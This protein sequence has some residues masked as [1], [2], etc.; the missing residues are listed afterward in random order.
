MKKKRP[1]S[2]VIICLL[3]LSV[4][5]VF[6]EQLLRN[7]LIGSLFTKTMVDR[8]HAEILALGGI[9]VAIASLSIPEKDEKKD[10][11]DEQDPE[12]K[13]G[14][15]KAK[16]NRRLLGKLLPHLNR[17]RTFALKE[18][19]DGIDG[20]MKICI[21]SEHGKIN[22]NE[23]FD[24]KKQ[25]FKKEYQALLKGLE[26]P[27]KMAA[28][29]M[30]KQITEFLK[31]RQR[32]LDDI[33]EL[34]LIPGFEQLNMFYE[35]P[36]RGTKKKKSEANTEIMLQDIFTIWSC[37]D[38]IEPLLFSDAL[39]AVFGIRRPTASDSSEMKEAFKK[40]AQSF[41]A[42]WLSDWDKNWP[43]VEPLYGEKPKFLKEMQP[44]FSKEFGPKVYSVLSCGKVGHV[45][46]RVLAL[47]RETAKKAQAPE[48]VSGQQEKV[49]AQG[50][51]QESEKQD[52]TSQSKTMFKID[53]IY[54]L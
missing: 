47:V 44:V 38:T 16:K 20:E 6:T 5:V 21:T 34:S 4:I 45:E 52:K 11:Q 54:W 40:I 9:Q 42:Q 29:E 10:G 3:V 25:E 37:R 8:E 26:I 17:W 1:G 49:P 14:S 23:A 32:K 50:Q 31:K 15:D 39:C 43:S 28:G 33:S 13:A 35:P 2:I 7:V 22:I 24:F 41:S 51:V 12:K 19:I 30:L 27:G 18:S 36:V 53:K 46:Q 48:K